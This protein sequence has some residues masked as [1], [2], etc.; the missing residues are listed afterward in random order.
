M[1]EIS[2]RATGEAQIEA[3]VEAIKAKW[4]EL[5]FIIL[6]YKEYKDKYTMGT[7]E[8]IL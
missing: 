5:N 8:D 6:P 4:A 7:V 2:A 1:E 3:Q